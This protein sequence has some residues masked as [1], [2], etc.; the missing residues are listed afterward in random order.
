M[1]AEHLSLSLTYGTVYL[2]SV[3]AGQV[4]EEDYLGIKTIEQ[5]LKTGP[6]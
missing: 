3:K 2:E 6:Q 5:A 4:P 1:P